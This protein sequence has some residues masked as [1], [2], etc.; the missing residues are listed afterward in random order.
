MTT[1]SK[2]KTKKSLQGQSQRISRRSS[3]Q[4]EQKL[5]LSETYRSALPKMKIIGIGGAGGNALNRIYGNI[6]GIDT[7]ALNT[8]VQDL[9]FTR[10]DYKIQ[11]GKNITFGR[12][13]GMNP[14]MG[15]KSA[16]ES[17]DEI[18]AALQGAELAFITCGLGGGTGSGAAPVVAEL[19]RSLN[20]VTIAVVT[21]PFTF[22]GKER[23]QIAQS[24]WNALVANVDALITVH[25][26]RIFS[27]IDA[28]T[29]LKKAF[30][31]VDEILREG[32]RAVSDLIIKPG[33]INVDFSD[34]KAVVQ[35][36][37]PALLGIAVASGKDRAESGAE[38]AIANPLVDGSVDNA[39]RVLLNITACGDLSMIEV[40]RVAQVI[41][42]RV[43]PS[44]K[45]IF[46]ASF[47]SSLGK[48]NMKVTV[49]ACDFDSGSQPSLIEEP[50]QSPLLRRVNTDLLHSEDAAAAKNSPL[51]KDMLGEKIKPFENFEDQPAFLRKKKR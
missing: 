3:R 49:V 6:K 31:H 34:L 35:H 43:N 32:I 51:L 19:C 45:I 2:K 12:G 9:R 36:A 14:E 15:R 11:I 10:A 27:I 22:E 8:D 13:A 23:S 29:S 16:E 50:P 37:G 7:I 26:D 46:G 33:L 5:K 48:G 1:R 42:E 40:Q 20:M 47:D 21:M 18:A 41:T 17:K 25:N 38:R 30:W 4:P 44:A 39:R 24:A 28:N